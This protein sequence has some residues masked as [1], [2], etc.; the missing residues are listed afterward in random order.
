M[1]DL[2]ERLRGTFA[3]MADEVPASADPRAELD[4]RLATRRSDRWR[5][6]VLVAAAAAVAAAVVVPVVVFGGSGS[7]PVSSGTTQPVAPASQSQDAGDGRQLLAR[8]SDDG[9]MWTVYAIPGGVEVCAESDPTSESCSQAQ[10]GTPPEGHVLTFAMEPEDG[11][12]ASKLLFV[13]TPEVAELHVRD[14]AGESVSL[15]ALASAGDQRILVAD[16]GGPSDGFGY[17]AK[18]ANGTVLEEALT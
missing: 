7:G 17:T 11:P 10:F 3:G 16:F 4:R 6:P 2:E 5:M 9:T 1:T 12:M 18:D 15:A 14:H 8:H 13:T